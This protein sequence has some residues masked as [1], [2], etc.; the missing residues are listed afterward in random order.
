MAE[1]IV[2]KAEKRDE[3][4]KNAARRM[5]VE[6]KVPVSI[7]GGGG[8]AVAATAMLSDLAAILRTDTGSKTVF[9]IDVAGEVVDVVFQ[10]RQIDPVMG[11]LIHADLR[12]LGKVEAKELADQAEAE[13][14]A[15]A[16]AAEAAEA[17]A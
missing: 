9:A 7:Y 15:A 17:E 3:R 8:E 1:K 10:E 14:Q 12:K 2:V 13:V 16:E 6:G 4:G 11:R 5:R